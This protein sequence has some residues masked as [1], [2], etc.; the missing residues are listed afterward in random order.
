MPT[1]QNLWTRILLSKLAHWH[2]HWTN[3]TRVGF[4][5]VYE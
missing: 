2:C 4:P 5:T 1:E 3:D